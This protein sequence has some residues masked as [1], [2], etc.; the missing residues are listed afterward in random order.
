MPKPEPQAN[1]KTQL[2]KG[3]LDLCILN[4][5]AAQEFYGY[6]LVQQLKQGEGTAM[7]EGIIYPVLA[8]LQDEGIVTSEKR[9]STS[10]PPRK[11]YQIT[12]KGRH[13]LQEM[14]AHWRQMT[15]AMEN[16]IQQRKERDDV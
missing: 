13:V 6:D 12:K 2:R 3:F 8:R 15:A 5:L 14:N 4:H 9:P 1:W 10:G 7:R 11:Y 16:S